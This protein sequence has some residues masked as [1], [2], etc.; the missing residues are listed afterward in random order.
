MIIETK[1]AASHLTQINIQFQKFHFPAVKGTY[2]TQLGVEPNPALEL[3]TLRD[4]ELS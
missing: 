4:Q 2:Y 1:N 3:T